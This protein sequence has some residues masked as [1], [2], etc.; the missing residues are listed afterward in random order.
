MKISRDCIEGCLIGDN[1]SQKELY[2]LL[3]PYLNALCSR[4]LNNISTRQDVLQ[5][6]FIVIFSKIE[7]FDSEKGAFHSWASRIVINNCLKQNKSGSRFTP[8]IN[9]KQEES[10]D[11]SVLSHLSNEELIRFLKTMPEKYSE[12]FMLFLIDDFSHEE[13]AEILGIKINLSRKRL[14]RARAWLKAKPI[15]LNSLLGDYRYS[16]S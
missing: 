6:S 4:Y 10:V 16:I 15:S 7:Q 9:E 5:D 14:A 8:F 1:S 3:L 11:P 2:E 13:I 12:V